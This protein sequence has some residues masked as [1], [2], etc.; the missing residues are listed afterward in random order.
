L[1]VS[2]V[3]SE[4]TAIIASVYFPQ[5]IWLA[6]GG[7]HGCKWTS[8]P[9]STVLKGRH[10][11]L[12]PDI[13]AY[14]DWKQKT[15][16]L[17]KSGLQVTISNLLEQVATDS[18][19]KSGLDIADYL[20]RF[21]PVQFNDLPA[22]TKVDFGLPP[23]MAPPP[24]SVLPPVAVL[25]SENVSSKAAWL[26]PKEPSIRWDIDSLEEFF[27]SVLL[28]QQPI[29]LDQCTVI[30]D[31]AKF[32]SGHLTILRTYEGKSCFIHYLQRLQKLKR[33]LESQ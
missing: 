30:M 15:G 17:S 13:K 4:K 6:T 16:E 26:T 10:I 20:I 7:K 14:D 2:I 11:T 19:C 23:S 29:R 21:K 25:T 12:W 18:E 32:I 27:N 28:P 31:L 3:E 8:A 33:L 1:P 24:H 9:V 5:F 22:I